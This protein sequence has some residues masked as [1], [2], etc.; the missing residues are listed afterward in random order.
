MVRPRPYQSPDPWG[1]FNVAWNKGRATRQE[2][3]TS[4][5]LRSLEEEAEAPATAAQDISHEVTPMQ[6]PGSSPPPLPDSPESAAAP[7]PAPTA[8]APASPPAAPIPNEVGS[9]GARTTCGD[10]NVPSGHGSSRLGAT[11]THSTRTFNP[12]SPS[13]LQNVRWAL[14]ISKHLDEAG[15]DDDGGLYTPARNSLSHTASVDKTPEG[16]CWTPPRNL[17]SPT[18]P[19]VCY[20]FHNWWSVYWAEPIEEGRQTAVDRVTMW[21]AFDEIEWKPVPNGYVVPRLENADEHERDGIVAEYQNAA[22]AVAEYARQL[23]NSQYAEIILLKEKEKQRRAALAEAAR[24]AAEF[25]EVA[26]QEKENGHQTLAKAAAGQLP[27]TEA[28]E[29]TVTSKTPTG[30]VD[31]PTPTPKVVVRPAF[32]APTRSKALK[33]M[34]EDYQTPS[35]SDPSGSDYEASRKMLTKKRPLSSSSESSSE[36]EEEPST[37]RRRPTKIPKLQL[38]PST[39]VQPS[40]STAP[41]SGRSTPAQT[42][43]PSVDQMR[44]VDNIR[45]TFYN[46]VREGARLFNAKEETILKQTGLGGMAKPQKMKLF[47]LFQAVTKKE[48]RENSSPGSCTR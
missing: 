6:A 28:A 9:P 18:P 24:E 15:L 29:H 10:E 2:E 20:K 38:V 25:A 47:N 17:D 40:R 33:P 39:P 31:L 30:S 35:E 14:D 27:S 36:E 44:F 26:R 45:S 23:L 42:G 41:K 16:P 22:F 3:Q 13:F 19:Q 21:R 12:G 8:L 34:N 37:S 48:A 1:G 32:A 11:I 46:S 4:A 43:R 7:E 5:Y